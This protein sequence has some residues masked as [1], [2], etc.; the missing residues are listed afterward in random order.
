MSGLI[1][2][3]VA[4]QAELT[5]WRRTI[6][7]NPETAFEEEK[8]AAFVAKVLQ[9]ANLRVDCGIAKTGVI[10]TL[11]G[12]LE[13]PSIALRADMDALNMTELNETAHRSKNPGKMHACGHDGHTV[14]LLAAARHLAQNRP[15]SGTVHFIFQ[16]AEEGQGGGR[17]M[18]EE[19]VVQRYGIDEVYGM[20]NWPDLPM[21]QIAVHSG[22]AMAAAD[23]FTIKLGGRGGHGAMP[24]Q[25]KDPVVAAAQII[26]ALQTIVSRNTDP[27]QSAVVSVT[28]VRAGETHNVI[29]E[30]AELCGT[31][32]SF[33]P[34]VRQTI[35]DK[36]RGLSTGIASAYGLSCIVDYNRG[37]PPTVNSH[38]EADFAAH[39][40]ASVVGTNG[41]L[42]Q[43]PPSMGAEDF[44][45][46]L[47]EK[48]GCYIWLGTG[49]NAGEPGLHH[50]R[51]DFNDQAIPIGASYWVK[52]VEERLSKATRA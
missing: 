26:T 36:I 8:T 4:Q 9:D 6:H 14:M 41:V 50:P 23:M 48:P 49:I 10:A 29:P 35:E 21:G 27:T 15:K 19:G 33:D 12:Q 52:L 44:A 34:R 38:S 30:S 22:P 24:H 46:F 7:A 5:E 28:C 1:K 45:Y 16:P 17:V 40:A 3:L 20:H 32:R 31:A 18:V 25:T 51:Y 39:V 13:G 47:N 11:K 2:E 42:R 43:M 37:Y